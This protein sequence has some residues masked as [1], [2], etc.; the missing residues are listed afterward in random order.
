M[1]KTTHKLDPFEG[2]VRFTLGVAL[3]LVAWDYG[4]T[5]IGT[6]AVVLALVSLATAVVGLSLV[7]RTRNATP[8]AVAHSHLGHDVHDRAHEGHP[9]DTESL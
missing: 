7:G 3:L 8:V 2:T 5:V 9:L 1:M 6:G 4:W